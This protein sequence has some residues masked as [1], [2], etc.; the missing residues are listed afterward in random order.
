MSLMLTASEPLAG[1]VM[2]WTVEGTNVIVGA[3]IVK[4]LAA[5]MPRLGSGFWTVIEFTP[6][7]R[8]SVSAKIIC[9]WFRSVKVVV[10]GEPFHNALTPVV[11]VFPVPVMLIVNPPVPATVVFGLIAVT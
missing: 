2:V 3:V 10:R 11:N 8:T 5:D 9:R 6:V 7:V 4:F 1:R